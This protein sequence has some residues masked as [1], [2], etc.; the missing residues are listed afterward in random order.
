MTNVERDAKFKAA[1]EE[2]IREAMADGLNREQTLAKLE[3]MTCFW[4]VDSRRSLFVQSSPWWKTKRGTLT[5]AGASS[6]RWSV[7]S[8]SFAARALG[9]SNMAKKGR[10]AKRSTKAGKRRPTTKRVA[11]KSKDGAFQSGAF[12]GFPPC[13]FR[14]YDPAWIRVVRQNHHIIRIDVCDPAWA[15]NVRR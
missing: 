8:F 11:A 5:E 15:R 13:P 1:C 3:E 14:K 6:F 2:Y 4:R 7:V 12:Q 10:T 9:D